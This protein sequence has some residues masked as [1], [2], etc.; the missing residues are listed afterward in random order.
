[1]ATLSLNI[2]NIQPQ[3][4]EHLQGKVLPVCTKAITAHATGKFGTDQLSSITT[5]KYNVTQASYVASGTSTT[6]LEDSVGVLQ[7]FQ[8]QP[9]AEQERSLVEHAAKPMLAHILRFLVD[10]IHETEVDEIPDHV[11][12]ASNRIRQQFQ[13]TLETS[14]S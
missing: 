12:D 1:M 5:P 7:D 10:E 4:P 11:S 2:C 9:A 3:S 13:S 14:L 6:I 8:P